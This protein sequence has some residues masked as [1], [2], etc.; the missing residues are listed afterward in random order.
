MQRWFILHPYLFG[1]FPVLFLYVQNAHR[2]QNGRGHSIFLMLPTAWRSSGV[3]SRLAT[4]RVNECNDFPVR[5]TFRRPPTP[6]GLAL[7]VAPTIAIDTRGTDQSI[8]PCIIELRRFEIRNAQRSIEVGIRIAVVSSDHS[9]CLSRAHI[10]FTLID[11][12][13]NSTDIFKSCFSPGY[14]VAY[15]LILSAQFA[16][17]PLHEYLHVLFFAVLGSLCIYNYRRCGRYHCKI[18]GPGY[19]GV[20]VLTLMLHSI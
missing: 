4:G 18:T 1:M 16:D 20:A 14:L 9:Y 11:A 5:V 15:A 6:F 12:M 8:H 3:L 17:Y 10:I 2:T 19:I 7:P 13:G